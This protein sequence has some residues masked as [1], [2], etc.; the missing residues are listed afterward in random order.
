MARFRIDWETPAG[1]LAAIE[2]TIADIAQ[3]AAALAAAYNDPHN[4]P[5]MGHAEPLSPDD[6]VEHYRELLADGDH[7]FLLYCDGE[8]AG[9]ADL[10]GIAELRSAQAAEFAFMVAARAA[11]GKGLGTKYAT[12]IHAFAFAQLGLAR[13]YAAVVPANVASRRV[14]EKLGHAIDRSASARAVADEDDDI[15]L[16]IDR[17]NFERTHA[18]I[19]TIRFTALPAG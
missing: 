11:Q 2:P 19:A 3:H 10:R 5:L 6:V 15:V 9:D 1:A 7:P 12:M 17:A 18:E 14:F 16:S 8:L 4:A 13:I